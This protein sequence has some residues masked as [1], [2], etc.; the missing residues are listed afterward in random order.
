MSDAMPSSLDRLLSNIYR[1]QREKLDLLEVV[2]NGTTG[3]VVVP[4]DSHALSTAIARIV[5]NPGVRQD[6]G[7]RSRERALELFTADECARVHVDAYR[8][9][10]ARSN[11]PTPAR[12]PA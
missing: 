12:R 1:P 3:F 5:E 7:R 8:V 11:R 2:E 9:A 4:E 6:L 10:L